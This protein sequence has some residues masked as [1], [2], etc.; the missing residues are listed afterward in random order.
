VNR[1][2]IFDVAVDI[3]EGSPSFGE[4]FGLEL[5]AQSQR[6]LFIPKGFAHGFLTLSDDTDVLYQM[7]VPFVAGFGGGIRWDDPSIG[8]KW[9]FPPA[10]INERDSGHPSLKEVFRH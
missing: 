4:W 3:R 2:A 5:D 7:S 10:V 9:P 8:I 6:A 1:G